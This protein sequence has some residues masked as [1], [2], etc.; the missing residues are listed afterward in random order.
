MSNVFG[1]A[2]VQLR[3]LMFGGAP[4][5]MPGPRSVYKDI[6]AVAAQASDVMYDPGGVSTTYNLNK[7]ILFGRNI[8]IGNGATVRTPANGLPA[9][10]AAD[11]LS[12][13]GSLLA[14]PY[15][16]GGTSSASG[17]DGGGGGCAIVIIARSITGSNG[18]VS[19]DGS[20]AGIAGIS[21]SPAGGQ[22]G[23][24]GSVF[25]SPVPLG[26]LASGY[27]YE[28]GTPGGQQSNLALQYYLSPLWIKSYL[29]NPTKPLY[30]G[31]GSEGRVDNS[32]AAD[33]RAE[34]GGG[35]AGFAGAG[36]NGA[37]FVNGS[38]YGIAGGG[39]GG[40]GFIM[41][42][43]ENSIPALVLSAQGGSGSA[44]SSGSDSSAGGGGGGGG[45]VGVYAPPSASV[46]VLVGGGYGAACTGA[47]GAGLSG[48]RGSEGIYLISA[49][50]D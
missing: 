36:G 22:A 26:A 19:C 31:G 21:L 24:S 34:G 29:L 37:V 1:T 11:T 20:Q 46:N 7:N 49:L 10:I 17:G 14:P 48:A 38:A 43:S 28:S 41:I 2:E 16:N 44:G 9:V 6:V 42:L 23:G 45:F 12:L 15:A 35:G 25:G 5:R 3:S 18:T 27:L 8:T 39:G 4:V 33:S 32:S 30:A 47:S 40:G 50:T 13:N